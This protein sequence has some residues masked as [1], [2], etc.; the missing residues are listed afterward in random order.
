MTLNTP[1]ANNIKATFTFKSFAKIIGEPTYTS[2]Y[3]LETQA[4]RNAATVAIRLNPPHINCAG[5][6]E[7]PAVYAL[8]VG[9]PFPRPTYPGDNPTYPIGATVVQRTN[10][11]NAFN[12]QSKNYSTKKMGKYYNF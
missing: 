10:I 11:L 12:T 2:L 4:T 8:R 3:K 6:V 9:A 1:S 5:I 7:Q